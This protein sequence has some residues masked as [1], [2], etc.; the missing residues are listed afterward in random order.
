[1]RRGVI[2]RPGENLGMPG[3][4]RVSVGT[5]EEIECFAQALSEALAALQQDV[6]KQAPIME[7]PT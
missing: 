5:P 2:V 1:M 3:W 4:V 7:H 6:P